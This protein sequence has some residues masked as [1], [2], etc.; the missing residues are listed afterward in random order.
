M[1]KKKWA[2]PLLVSRLVLGLGSL[3]AAWG[4]DDTTPSRAAPPATTATTVGP[5]TTATTAAPTTT[6]EAGVPDTGQT[7]KLKMAFHVPSRASIVGAYYQP[8]ADAVAAATK[9][10]VT[11]EMYAEETLVKEADQ[12]DAVKSGLADIASCSSDATPGRFP[13]AD[14]YGLPELFPS[15]EVASRVYWDILNE[16]CVDEYKDFV[17]L[18]TPTIAAAQYFGNKEAKLPADM[19]GQRVRSGGEIEAWLIEALGATPVEISTGELATSMERGMADSCFLSWSFGLITGVKDSTKFRT[20]T[21]MFY[22][23]FAIIMNKDVWN[24]MPKTLQDAI[25]SVSGGEASGK[26]SAANEALAAE[27]KGAIAGSD[28]GA[29]NPPI[30]ELTADELAQWKAAALPVWDKW[31]QKVG[32]NAQA[33]VDKAKVLIDKYAALPPTEVTTTTAPAGTTGI[34]FEDLGG[35]KVHL[36]IVPEPGKK[37]DVGTEGPFGAKVEGFDATGKSLGALEILES[38]KGVLDY[39]AV[40]GIAKIVATDAAHGGATYEYLIP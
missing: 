29:G 9:G 15:A 21:N 10:R 11:I 39:S 28:K 6:T 17:I 26:Y 38:A 2:L 27:D 34:F 7:Y 30:T 32:G 25:M 1:K 35:G 24:S 3:L 37:F 14:F 31:V 4:G 20:E 8:W 13:L 23:C 5:V 36:S 19:A 33:L 16:F 22:R 12:V 40:K 18:G